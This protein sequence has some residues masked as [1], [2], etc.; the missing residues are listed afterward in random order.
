MAPLWPAFL[1]LFLA[2]RP[3]FSA[4]IKAVE[5]ASPLNS[6][7]P[8]K[9]SAPTD[10]A[11]PASALVS[12]LDGIAPQPLKE[13][14]LPQLGAGH[15]AAAPQSYAQVPET[16]GVYVGQAKPYFAV[17]LEK[18]GASMSLVSKLENYVASPGRH[19]GAQNEVYHG[20][21]HTY[22]VAAVVARLLEHPSAKTL[23]REQKALILLSAVFHDI[24]PKRKPGD[25][26]SVA[27]TFDLL[28]GD[29]ETLSVLEDIQKELGVTGPQLKAMIKGTDFSPRQE[30]RDAIAADSER[31]LKDQFGGAEWAKTWSQHIANGDKLASYVADGAYADRLVR[32]LANEL[33][34]KPMDGARNSAGVIRVLRHTPTFALPPAGRQANY[35]RVAKHY[36]DVAV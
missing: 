2:A 29:L 14:I 27:R 34:L 15:A 25:P 10:L 32:G 33:G 31:L 22:D 23:T 9:L 16:R 36:E 35:A 28:S 20:L 5:I 21:H 3:A 8:Q 12:P 17:A 13:S 19:P 6:A 30:V 26:A 11:L 4:D 18:L 1:A 7:V 24:D